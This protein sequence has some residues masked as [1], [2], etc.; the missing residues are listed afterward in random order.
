[1]ND[2][3][4][5]ALQRAQPISSFISQSVASSRIS[6][7]DLTNEKKMSHHPAYSAAAIVAIGGSIGYIKSKS[8]PSL[9]AGLGFSLLFFGSGYL[10]QHNRDYGIESAIATSSLLTLSML[11]KALKSK[12]PVPIA[13]SALGVSSLVY[14]VKK[15][16][17]F[18]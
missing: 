6:I 3:G 10:L 11:P 7:L 13:L 14:Y 9:I 18:K 1:M 8:K 5:R 15:F 4:E 12:K 2:C 16:Y 17:E